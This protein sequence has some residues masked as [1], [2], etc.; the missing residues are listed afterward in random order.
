MKFLL[1]ATL[2]KLV[3]MGDL[4]LTF[5]DG[6]VVRFGDATGEPVHIRFNSTQAERA[7]ALDPS[8]K[9]AEAYMDGG[10]DLLKGDIYTALKVILENSSNPALA[11]PWMMAIEGARHIA[12]RLQQINTLARASSN[13]RHHY[14]LSGELYR[15]FLDSDMQYSCAYFEEPDF[16]IEE[17]QL[18]KKRHI[19]AKL[20]VEEG[21]KVLDIGCGWGGLGL[22]LAGTLG[23]N[24]TG[25]TLSTEQ[26]AVA[27]ERAEAEGLA[28]KADFRLLDYRKV[29][30]TF[31]RLVSV[32]MFEHV[33][34]NHYRE[35][36][37][38]AARLRKPDGVFLL[39]TIG[40]SD[41]PSSTNAFIRKHIFPG[42]YIPSMSEVLPHIE[43]TGLVVTDV[44][45][46]RLHYAETLRA[47]RERFMA[48]RDKARAIY[49]ERFCR[50]WEFY[51]AGSEAAFRWQN[52]V[53]FQFQIARDQRSVPLTRN[54]IGEAE[55]RLKRLDSPR[56]SANTQMT[57]RKTAT[58]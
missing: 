32:G 33:G 36:F 48:N 19:T 53:V 39:H 9:F 26:H 27:R 8:L 46:L 52:L 23:A 40:R 25:V 21:H 35:Y 49:D 45:V 4:T 31:D 18:A 22:Y 11:E 56:L 28:E 14:D 41:V 37:R 42:G 55:Q 58:N 2:S 6:E 34:V 17:A 20:L 44:E 54:Y 50:M 5:A 43:R 16:T 12:R 30:G 3:K 38:H 57:Q 1:R 10:F 13:V 47:W 15:L 51:L 7:V 29:E 24:V